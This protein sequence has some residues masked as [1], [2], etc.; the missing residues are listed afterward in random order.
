MRRTRLILNRRAEFSKATKARA[1]L[2]AEGR[3]EHVSE[4]GIR[5]TVVFRAGNTP[6][7]DHI[8]AASNGGSSDPSNCMVMCRDH[9]GEKTAKL[10][11][12]R[13]AKTERL[14]QKHVAGIR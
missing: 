6:H 4:D 8:I 1:F 12:P 5:C 11:I 14:R 7:Y 2:R 13:A 10:D 9:H 3:C